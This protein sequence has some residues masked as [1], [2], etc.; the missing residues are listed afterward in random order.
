M[1]DHRGGRVERSSGGRGGHRREQPSCSGGCFLVELGS[2]LGSS[3]FLVQLV[4]ARGKLGIVGLLL[5]ILRLRSGQL[6]EVTLIKLRKTAYLLEHL[7]KEKV[8][9]LLVHNVK[10]SVIGSINPSFLFNY[11]WL[12]TV[13]E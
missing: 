9:L 12:C 2:K 6:A 7:G 5:S 10:V 4:N 3:R 11:P 1:V 13:Q 8:C